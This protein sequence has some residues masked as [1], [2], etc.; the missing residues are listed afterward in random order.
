MEVIYEAFL[1]LMRLDVFGA[2]LGPAVPL[3]KIAS[4]GTC[5]VFWLVA[6]ALFRP[7]A[8]IG[9]AQALLVGGIF[10]PTVFDQA[11][12]LVSLDR[13]VGETTLAL[14]MLRLDGLQTLFS[15]SVLVLAF[16]EGVNGWPR[17]SDARHERGLRLLFL[18]TFGLCLSA[19]VLLL[20]HGGANLP[21]EL[22]ATIQAACAA[23]ILASVSVAIRYRQTHPLTRLGACAPA[24]PVPSDADRQLGRRVRQLVLAEQAWLDPDLKVADLARRLQEPDYRISRAIT[25]GLGE[26]NFNRFINRFR[27]DQAKA[28]L[29]DPT[30]DDQAI[31]TIALDSGFA[32]IGPFNRAF[33]AETG[34]TPRQYRTARGAEP[35]RLAAE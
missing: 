17:G 11:A 19:C 6:R 5:S 23:I 8:R 12:L 18:S 33:K 34:Q 20:D 16:W 3:L 14:I 27:L 31:L 30:Q 10:F 28:A 7:G 35:S 2:A 25:A 13:V 4:C 21:A 32:S 1:A 29:A 15:S 24:R 22:M 26:A 9:W